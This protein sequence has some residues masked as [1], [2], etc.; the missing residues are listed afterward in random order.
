MKKQILMILGVMMVLS[1]CSSYNYYSVSNKKLNIGY[2]TYAWLPDGKSKASN[3]YDNDVAADRIVEAASTELNNRGFRLNNKKPD[4]LVRY[5]AVANK[6]TKSYNEPVYYDAPGRYVPRVGVYR[7]RA[8]YYYAYRNPFPVY[9]GNEQRTVDV[10]QGSIMIDLI[11]RRTKKVIWRG[12]AEGELNNPEKAI[13]Q[14]PKVIG[15]IFK[16]LPV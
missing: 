8:F 1:S 6:E 15:N 2:R 14:L 5:T 4:L 11:D 7:G 10:K 12:W 16:K 13:S 9:V 3:I